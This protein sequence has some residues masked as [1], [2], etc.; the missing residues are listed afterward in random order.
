MKRLRIIVLL[1]ILFVCSN[2]NA[3]NGPLKQNSIIECDGVYYGKHGT[4]AHWHKAEKKNDK[5][6]SVGGE[7]ELPPC[8]IKVPNV[9]EKVVFSKCSDGDTAWFKING[10]EKKVRFLAIDT[11]EVGDNP[12][13]FGKEASNYTCNTLKNAKEIYLE[14]D[15]A[16]DKEDKYGRVLAFVYVDGKLLEQE[17][18]EK[19]LA[20]V[21][22]IYGD[23]EHVDEL[24]KQEEIAKENKV[25]IWSDINLAD[26]SSNTSDNTNENDDSDDND[27]IKIIRF[28]ID[29]IKKIFALLFN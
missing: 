11:P 9:K 17:L 16:S 18:I 12:E 10:E 22:Y 21:A 24:R 29:I 27:I 14:Y 25:G 13:P 8:Y 26:E 7:V 4:P 2:V 19:G 20:K 28:I 3:T 23:Y 15:G 1:V 6:V 5:W